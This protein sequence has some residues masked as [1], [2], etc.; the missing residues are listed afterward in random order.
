MGECCAVICARQVARVLR[1]PVARV[2]RVPSGAR[3]TFQ[4]IGAAALSRTASTPKA[5]R[6]PSSSLPRIR[7]A[8]GAPNFRCLRTPFR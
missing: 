1:V 4:Y 8:R 5:C 7:S 6:K 3:A 2:L